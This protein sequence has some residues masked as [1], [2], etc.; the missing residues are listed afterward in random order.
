MGST[1][2][3][4]TNPRLKIFRNKENSKKLQKAKLEFATSGNYLHSIYKV[5]VIV[6]I[7]NL[8]I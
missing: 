7:S 8:E 6:S 1:Y 2:A 5:L 4:S 3:D